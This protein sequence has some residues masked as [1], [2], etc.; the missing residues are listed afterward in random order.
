MLDLPRLERLSLTRHPL[1][2][3]LLGRILQ[4][5]YTFLPGT[6]IEL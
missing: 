1:T 4:A 6:K 2:Q 5:N 3:R